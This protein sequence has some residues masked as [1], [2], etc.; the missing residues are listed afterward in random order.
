MRPARSL[1]GALALWMLFIIPSPVG[2]TIIRPTYFGPWS[3]LC[4]EQERPGFLRCSIRY[5]RDQR[6]Q[7]EVALSNGDSHVLSWGLNRANCR[8]AQIREGIGRSYLLSTSRPIESE[9]LEFAEQALQV[10]RAHASFFGVCGSARRPGDP[11]SLEYLETVTPEF[12][13]AFVAAEGRLR[14][15]VLRAERSAG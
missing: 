8:H 13:N 14:E 9:V 6:V 7:W 11:V 12:I 2:A 15:F 1:A 10:M 3:L 5:W 4:L